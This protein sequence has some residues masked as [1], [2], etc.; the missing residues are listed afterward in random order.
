MKSVIIGLSTIAVAYSSSCNGVVSSGLKQPTDVCFKA[1]ATTSYLHNCTTNS[2][3]FYGASTVCSGILGFTAFPTT[4]ADGNYTSF[5]CSETDCSYATAYESGAALGY[6]LDDCVEL[7]ATTSSYLKLECCYTD[8]CINLYLDSA[9]SSASKLT[10]FSG[11]ASNYLSNYTVPDSCDETSTTPAPVAPS[12]S[13][14]PAPYT[15]DCNSARI[16]YSGI[17]LSAPTGVCVASMNATTN[18]SSMYDCTTGMMHTYSTLDCTGS[19][20]TDT[21][22]M[23][24]DAVD[25]DYAILRSYSNGT[26]GDCAADYAELA[27]TMGCT[28]IE[29]TE[30]APLTMGFDMYCN[31]DNENQTSAQVL[32]GGCDSLAALNTYDDAIEAF[33]LVDATLD[34]SCL[35]MTCNVAPTPSPTMDPT[36]AE[37]DSGDSA[38][39]TTVGAVGAL[40]AATA[41]LR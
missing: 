38:W 27:L 33:A 5:E 31:E 26:G 40:L 19:Y 35:E 3:I 34:T 11:S 25:C 21:T 7:N 22:D 29:V 16:Y 20:T 9:C 6:V 39:R 12:V 30:P 2:T 17:P 32:I 36:E 1:S 37:G 23:V 8:L 18:S 10:A 4:F 28:T 13:T 15:S 14:T 24:C 41:L